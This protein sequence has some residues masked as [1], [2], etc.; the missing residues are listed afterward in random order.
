VSRGVGV[1]PRWRD[2]GKEL[3]YADVE[4]LS[5]MAVDVMSDKTLK[6][7]LRLLHRDTLLQLF[8]PIE[9]DV[10]LRRG[11]LIVLGLRSC[12]DDDELLAVRTDVVVSG[13]ADWRRSILQQKGLNHSKQST[14]THRVRPSA[15]GANR[16]A[17]SKHG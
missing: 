2:D 12:E 1:A 9:D 4:S 10:E 13:E 7:S 6:S 5:E 3:V 14:G 8:Q 17:L 15:S 16:H 11:R